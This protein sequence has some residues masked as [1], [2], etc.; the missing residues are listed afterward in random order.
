[1]RERERKGGKTEHS[2]GKTTHAIEST[3]ERIRGKITTKDTVDKTFVEGM[4]KRGEKEKVRGIT[5]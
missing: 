5:N 2:N 3:Q 4:R 1:M